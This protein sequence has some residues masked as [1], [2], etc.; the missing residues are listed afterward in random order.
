MMVMKNWRKSKSAEF[1]LVR[2]RTHRLKERKREKERVRKRINVSLKEECK[3]LNKKRYKEEF[4]K[5]W[6]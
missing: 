6:K 5:K 2:D 3:Y 4:V 1:G